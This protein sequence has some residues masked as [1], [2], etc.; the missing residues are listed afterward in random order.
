M[1]SNARKTTKETIIRL[2]RKKTGFISGEE[3]ADTLGITRAAVWKNVKHLKNNGYVIETRRSKGYR[4]MKS[5]DLSAEEI[6]NLLSGCTK[7]IGRDILFFD[8]VNST[9]TAASEFASKGYAEGSVIIANGQTEGRGRRGRAWLSPPGRNIYMSIILTP[10]ISPVDATVL[11]LMAAVACT[12]AVRNAA[13][14]Q[15][16]IKWPNDIIVSGKKI[17]GILT[18]IKADMDRI[19]HSIIGIGMNINLDID[20]MPDSLRA[21]ATSIKNE[22]GRTVSR[23]A[24]AAEILKELDKWYNVFLQA[25]KRRIIDEWLM[26]SSTIGRTVRITIGD[27]IFMGIAESI[28][29]EGML[30]LKLPD[31]TLKKISAGDVVILR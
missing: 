26:L 25:G 27:N 22:T 8:M 1:R 9:N 23:T 10:D 21:T 15:V 31:K 19:F 20:E 12:H 2:L 18:E 6:R 17:G 5:P 30:M 4:L 16:S 13:S 11:T 24:M 14:L 7:I 29:D 3:M 28:T